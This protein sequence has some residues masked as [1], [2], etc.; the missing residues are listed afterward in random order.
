MTSH[1]SATTIIILFWEVFLFIFL[2]ECEQV[3]YG[4]NVHLST[5]DCTGQSDGIVEIGCDG[6]AECRSH[7][8]VKT[9]CTDAEVFNRDARRC[10]PW[11]FNFFFLFFFLY[12]FLLAF[13]L[14]FLV[15]FLPFILFS[16][17]FC[18]SFFILF[19]LISILLPFILSFLSLICFFS[20]FPFFRPLILLVIPLSFPHWCLLRPQH[21][22]Q[23]AI[24]SLNCFIFN[25]AVFYCLL[26]HFTG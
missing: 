18:H 17:A 8:L 5:F 24:I 7:Q 13:F 2:T 4:Y 25:V 14:S 9:L 26:I 12:V 20:C 21:L 3:V 15:A 22:L 23:G 10:V 6:Y 1:L 19:F 11:D 16:F